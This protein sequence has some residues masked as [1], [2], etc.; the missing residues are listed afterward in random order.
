MSMHPFPPA[1]EL[2]LNNPHQLGY[3]G[4]S[5]RQTMVTPRAYEMLRNTKLWVRIM[6]VLM[7]LLAGFMLLGAGIMLLSALAQPHPDPIIAMALFYVPLSML[8]IA[9]AIYLWKYASYT[10]AFCSS[11]DELNLEE[12]LKAQKS[13]LK[14][15]AITALVVIALYLLAIAGFV[16]YFALKAMHR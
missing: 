15:T 9:P 10:S 1:A 5:S 6:S 12:A 4:P 14:Y 2:P 3:M 16:V 8:Y 7:F 13:F 11:R